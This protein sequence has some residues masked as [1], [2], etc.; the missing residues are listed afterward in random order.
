M[1][2]QSNTFNF[3]P[4]SMEQII[5]SETQKNITFKSVFFIVF[6]H[7]VDQTAQFVSLF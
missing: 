6:K 2:P 7:S 1:Q 3:G 4:F 5:L